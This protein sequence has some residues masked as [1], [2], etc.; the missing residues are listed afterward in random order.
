MEE[1]ICSM[2]GKQI[3][4]DGHLLIFSIEAIVHKGCLYKQN[5]QRTTEDNL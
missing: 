4:G 5:E 3:N 2:C 1:K